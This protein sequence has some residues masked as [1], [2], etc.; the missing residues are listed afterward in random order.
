M[1]NCK[2][3]DDCVNNTMCALRRAPVDEESLY[4]DAIYDTELA[5]RR[6]YEK[7][8]INIMEGFGNSKL[9]FNM[10][11]RLVILLLIVYLVYMMITDS[12]I[13]NSGLGGGWSESLSDLS[14]L[15]SE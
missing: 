13:G 14:F 8:P 10:V 1:N 6:C 2:D 3:Y 15:K 5:R 7:S 9:T 12:K 11:L 4:A